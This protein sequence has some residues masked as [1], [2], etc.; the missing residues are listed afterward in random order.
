ME[1]DSVH[2]VAAA[3]ALT[4]PARV[5]PTA[6]QAASVVL[7]RRWG[8]VCR[9]LAAL[10]LVLTLLGWIV[11]PERTSA[12]VLM[13]SQY[14][15]G[16]SLAGLLFIA[17]TYVTSA[18]WSVAIR[19]VPEALAGALP[20]GAVA[21]LIAALGMHW[22]YPWSRSDVVAHDELLQYKSGFLSIGGFLF[23]TIFFLALWCAF[24]WIMRRT[25]R[26]Q[27]QTRSPRET[28]R[29]TVFSAI[30]LVV[31]AYTYSRAIVDW[32]MS[33]E[34]HWYSTVFA[35]YNF[36][37][38][39]TSGLAAIILLL[40]VLRRMGKFDALRPAHLHDLSKLLF[41]FATFW[42]YIWFCQY[43]L[44]WYG[45]I[46]EE[47]VYYAARQEGAWSVLHVANPILNWLIP[48]LM[49]LP[50]ANKRRESLLIKVCILI[51]AAHWIDLFY[52]VGPNVMPAGPVV[53]VWEIA[54]MLVAV[55]ILIVVVF[56]VLGRGR[57]VPVGDPYLEE[58][59]HH[60]T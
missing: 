40:I 12:G 34:P 50:S 53:G 26:L 60:E 46:P 41:G 59:L 10:G 5:A 14:V 56:K 30:F 24:A 39:F 43:M 49:L 8:A 38:Y 48:F 6:P 20:V 7:P 31:F 36:S 32:V 18:G 37:G 21:V 45:N 25:S 11:A 13:A 1:G 42:A 4:A 17:M 55:P 19:R 57:L 3:E 27:D 44:I 33:M 52:M 54:P 51:L 23:R 28:Q 58:S 2:P 22:L 29:N 16:I 15:L 35:I 9:T 47:T